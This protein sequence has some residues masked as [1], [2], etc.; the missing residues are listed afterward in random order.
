MKTKLSHTGIG[1]CL[2]IIDNG[3]TYYKASNIIR[4]LGYS[5]RSEDNGCRWI[6][7]SK[8]K[9]YCTSE[10]LKEYLSKKQGIMNK[11][12]AEKR[13]IVKN[14]KIAMY[15]FLYGNKSNPIQ[16]QKEQTQPKQKACNCW[17]CILLKSLMH[18]TKNPF[19]VRK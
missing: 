13:E 15:K 10:Q 16:K 3:E 9:G 1:R 6:G 11:M 17:W 18:K 14:R 12:P 4:L 2:T 19:E 7:T 5:K 8:Y